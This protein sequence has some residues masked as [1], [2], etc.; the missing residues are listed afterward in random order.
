MRN[1]RS[2][3]ERSRCQR[4][5]R[6]RFEF[7][8]S[9]GARAFERTRWKY[10]L[11]FYFQSATLKINQIY[12]YDATT[13]GRAALHN[14][15]PFK[16]ASH[17]SR[18]MCFARR[19]KNTKVATKSM[20]KS[21]VHYAHASV[22]KGKRYCCFSDDHL[23]K[24]LRN[25]R[26]KQPRLNLTQYECAKTT[27]AKKNISGWNRQHPGPECGFRWLFGKTSTQARRSDV[28][29]CSIAII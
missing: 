6:R 28:A 19:K 12:S 27:L 13:T 26:E 8:I 4:T 21:W 5:L 15:R 7:L 14:E 24:Q 2:P 1:N 16:I 10:L 23:F 11:R 29:A 9:V 3:R 25:E 18:K 22:S 20:S 17:L